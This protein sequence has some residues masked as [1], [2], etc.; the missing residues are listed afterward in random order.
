MF[1]SQPA[2]NHL[3]VA[4]SIEA[5]LDTPQLEPLPN[6]RCIVNPLKRPTEILKGCLNHPVF[7]C[8]LS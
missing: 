1:L 3:P 5:A 7:H 6:A 4:F 8:R 2:P